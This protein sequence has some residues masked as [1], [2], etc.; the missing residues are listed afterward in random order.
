MKWNEHTSESFIVKIYYK[1]FNHMSV[2]ATGFEPA[3]S[4]PP[5]VH[6]NQTEPHPVVQLPFFIIQ[7]FP[8][9]VNA[10]SNKKSGR[11]I[12][13]TPPAFL[14]ALTSAIRIFIK[15]RIECI[16]VFAVQ[17]FLHDP[18]IFTESLVMHDFTLTQETNR[19]TD[20]RIFYKPENVIVSRTGFL[21]WGD[22]VS[23]TY[24]KI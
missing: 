24:T 17:V 23:T 22:L 6:S 19:I 14:W 5:A 16:E 15:L 8:K 20:F 13:I 4:R 1:R 9:K 3:T 18:K 11:V 7:N 21:F 10:L 12:L 2:G